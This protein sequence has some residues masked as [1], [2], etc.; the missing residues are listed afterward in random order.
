[1]AF[2]VGVDDGANGAAGV[3]VLAADGEQRAARFGA[4]GRPELLDLR[5]DELVVVGRLAHERRHAH[6]HRSVPHTHT[7]KK[8]K[9]KQNKQKRQP[10]SLREHEKT[11]LKHSTTF[12]VVVEK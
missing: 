8:P 5:V 10:T 9:K 2:E 12:Q 1:M 4:L 3:H 7:Q 6:H 11:K